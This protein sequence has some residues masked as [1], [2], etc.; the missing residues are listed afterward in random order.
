[1]HKTFSVIIKEMLTRSPR[2]PEMFRLIKLFLI[3]L[4][5]ESDR[6]IRLTQDESNR[7]MCSQVE[8]YIFRNVFIYICAFSEYHEYINKF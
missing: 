2:F 8:C 5:S 7:N 6:N 1:M 4:I 3:H